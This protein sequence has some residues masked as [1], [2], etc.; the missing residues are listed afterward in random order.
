MYRDTKFFCLMFFPKEAIELLPSFYG[1]KNNI[2]KKALS[3]R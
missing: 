3:K 2:I 1:V